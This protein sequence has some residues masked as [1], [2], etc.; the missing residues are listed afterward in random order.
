MTL[1]LKDVK[2]PRKDYGRLEDGTYPARIVQVVDF[3]IQKQT[4]WQTGEETDPKPRLMITWE[5]PGETITIEDKE[6]NSEERPRWQG[7]EY[8][9]SSFEQAGLMKLVSALKPDLESFDELL[10]LPCMIQVGSTSGGK[11]KI[12]SVM[13]MPKGVPVGDLANEPT[14]FD[15]DNPNRELFES[16]PNWQQEKIKSALNY[17][18]FADTWTKEAVES[19]DD[20]EGEDVPF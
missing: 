2:S 10:N 4:D 15:F 5:V 18:G 7:R 8:T 13:S 14:M 9:I 19:S 17:D 16:L 12:T 6:G 1:I 20:D 11:A 3:G